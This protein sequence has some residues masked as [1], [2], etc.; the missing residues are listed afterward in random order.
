MKFKSLVAAAAIALTCLS[1]LATTYQLNSLKP[2]D[3]YLS[4]SETT[5]LTVPKGSFSDRFDFSLGALTALDASAGVLNFGKFKITDTSFNYTLFNS[6]NA[7]LGTGTNTDV[8]SLI[9]LAVGNY[10]LIVSG[11][12]TGLSGGKYNGAI[13]TAVPEP[14]TFAML[15]AGLGLMGGIARRRSKT[16][17]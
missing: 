3:N 17:A 11:T 15:L 1:A 4:G 6:S 13:T 16:A 12:A 5:T 14:E 7:L 9:N 10:Y 2:G 8:L